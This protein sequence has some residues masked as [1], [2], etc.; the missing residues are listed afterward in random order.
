VLQQQDD[1]I[2]PGHI[3]QT[4]QSGYA[5]NERAVRPAS[6]SVRPSEES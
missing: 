3:V 6:V 2:E 4:L 1:A 5:L